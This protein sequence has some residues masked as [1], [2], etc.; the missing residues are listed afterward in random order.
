MPWGKALAGA[1]RAKEG[2]GM[3]TLCNASPLPDAPMGDLSYLDFLVLNDIEAGVLLGHEEDAGVDIKEMAE[4]LK[5]QY[6]CGGVIITNGEHG[7]GVLDGDAWTEVAPVAVD[8]VYT[9]G[10]GDGYLA[11]FVAGLVRGMTTAEA[12]DY[13]GKY[14]AYKVTREGSMT[15]KPGKGYPYHDEVEAFLASLE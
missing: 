12:A 2:Y 8:A 13:A 11:A 10:A 3:V 14:S 4:E 1:K 6:R 15:K 7:S 9:I 5:K